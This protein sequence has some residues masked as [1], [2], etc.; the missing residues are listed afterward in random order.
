[1]PKPTRKIPLSVER[2]GSLRARQAQGAVPRVRRGGRLR[3]R[4]AQGALP[5][6]QRVGALRARQAQA[7]V[8]RVRRVGILRARQVEGA[9]WCAIE[10]LDPI[11]VSRTL[12]YEAR[13]TAIKT[14]PIGRAVMVARYLGD[15]DEL[16][17]IMD[18]H[19]NLLRHRSVE[20]VA[21][22]R[23]LK[24]Q[25][26]V[27]RPSA[28]KSHGYVLVPIFVDKRELRPR[29]QPD[30]KRKRNAD[31]AG[32][33]WEVSASGG[34]SKWRM[35]AI[36]RQRRARRPSSQPSPRQ[37]TSTDFVPLLARVQRRLGWSAAT[38][39]RVLREYRRFLKLKL[40]F[41][42]YDA[43]KLSPPLMIDEIW[44]MHVLDTRGARHARVRRRLREDGWKAHPP[45]RGPARAR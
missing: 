31:G 19:E 6:L 22:A 13:R 4:Q 3:A 15:S 40:A 1:M 18:P 28:G 20:D 12:K 7:A 45:R 38:A 33:R 8:P 21:R 14:D 42:D 16:L 30:N 2:V 9:L 23:T 5:R 39:D 11:R 26:R 41:H 27:M 17:V 32:S 44:H 37:L 43:D 25:C 35:S 29:E 24:G 34:E 10:V 36:V